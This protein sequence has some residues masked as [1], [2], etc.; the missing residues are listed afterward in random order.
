MQLGTSVLSHS[1]LTLGL[2]VCVSPTLHAQ[3]ATPT[4]VKM[5][6]GFA[7]RDIT[8]DIGMEAPVATERATI[9]C[10]MILA[11]CAQQCLMMVQIKSP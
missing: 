7:E 2:C 1:L 5:Q 11:K 8:P 4:P 6:A 3:T 10:F 9:K